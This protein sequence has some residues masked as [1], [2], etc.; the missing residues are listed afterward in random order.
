M[1]ISEIFHSIQGEGIL[2]GVSSIFVRTSGCNLRCTWCDTPYTSWKPE[3]TDQSVEEIVKQVTSYP[4]K[5]TVLTGGEPMLFEES[6]ALCEQLKALGHHITVETAG[7]VFRPIPCDLM[8]ISPKLSNSTPHHDAFWSVQHDKLRLQPEVL[9]KLMDHADYQLKFV[10]STPADLEE[11]HPLVQQ[12]KADPLKVL[13][14]PEGRDAA[15]LN[16]RSVWIAD[17]CKQFGY[18]YSPRLHVLLWGDRRGI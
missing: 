6:M 12:L 5:H 7:T 14:M 16:E 3:G 15:T 13:L 9:R 8:S 10:V 11:I 1:K 17:I 2:A 4:A 18:R